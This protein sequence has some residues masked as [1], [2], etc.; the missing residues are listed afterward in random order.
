MM[1]VNYKNIPMENASLVPACYAHAHSCVL[2]RIT[3]LDHEHKCKVKVGRILA[4]QGNNQYG[5]VPYQFVPKSS[6]FILHS[7]RKDLHVHIYI[8][9]RGLLSVK[10]NLT[11][12]E[13]HA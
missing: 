8:S 2:P 5:G 9:R 6:T 7:P 4:M 1:H 3:K 13:I 10:P 11:C 12:N